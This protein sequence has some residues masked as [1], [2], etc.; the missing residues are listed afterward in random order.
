MYF[1][2]GE[3]VFL[4]SSRPTVCSEAARPARA[5][6]NPQKPSDP[7]PTCQL[8]ELS[9]ERRCL[10]RAGSGATELP[11]GTQVA[12]RTPACLPQHN[13]PCLRG[14]RPRGCLFIVRSQSM[15]TSETQTARL[16]GGD[17]QTALSA[18]LTLSSIFPPLGPIP[19]HLMNCSPRD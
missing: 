16:V 13:R 6:Q 12:R 17:G 19:R 3:A 10:S 2:A 4:L 11:E 5:I 7:A 15:E 1:W 14:L 8:E 18:R 9:L